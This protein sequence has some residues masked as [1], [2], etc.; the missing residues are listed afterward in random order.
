MALL[1][2]RGENDPVQLTKRGGKRERAKERK[3]E[4]D[5]NSVS[6]YTRYSRLMSLNQTTYLPVSSSRRADPKSPRG[7]P[8]GSRA[9][10]ELVATEREYV[11][12]LAL[13]SK[14]FLRPLRAGDVPEVG[15]DAVKTLFQNW[16]TLYAANADLLARLD[17]A[18]GVAGAGEAVRNSGGE[19]ERERERERETHTSSTAP[20][21]V[22]RHA[23]A[24][25]GVYCGTFGLAGAAQVARARV[26]AFCAVLPA[27][28]GA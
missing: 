4:R 9:F 20:R 25:C 26:H 14:L 8:S 7:A 16:E 3:S 24:V 27:G 10:D 21:G 2:T 22:A 1:G 23:R 28:E 17:N 19:R 18:G 6:S 13:V 11:R 12:S 15:E 5:R